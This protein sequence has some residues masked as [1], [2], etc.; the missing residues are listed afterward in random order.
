MWIK[1][2][3]PESSTV[4]TIEAFETAVAAPFPISSQLIDV[5]YFLMMK[6][7]AGLYYNFDS[8]VQ[9]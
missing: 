6:D 8:P 4:S 2:E 7:W 9:K 3:S 5:V 1:Q